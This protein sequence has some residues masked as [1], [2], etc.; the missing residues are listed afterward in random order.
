[1]GTTL[2]LALRRRMDGCV[3]TGTGNFWCHVLEGACASFGMELV[4]PGVVF[5][6]LAAALG[7]SPALMGALGA[8]GGLS[9]LVPLF[10][11]HRVEAARRKKR[12]VLLLG[13]GQ[14]LPFLVIPLLLFLMAESAPRACLLSIALVNLAAAMVVSALVPPWV[15][16]LSETIRPAR[17][18][19]L[20][21]YRNS[22]SSVLGLLAGVVSA[23][24]LSALAFPLGYVLLYLFAFGAMAASWLIFSLVD[25]LPARAEQPGS[26]AARSYFQGLF[27]A[28]RDDA[29]CR[30]YLVHQ[31]ISRMGMAVAP[32][33]ALVAVS[34]FGVHP[35]LAVGAFLTA[36]NSAKIAGSFAFP[37]FSE[38]A[39]HRWILGI[40]TGLHAAAALAAACAPSGEWFVAV[41]FLSGLG[42]AA[43]TVSG[44]PLT[45]A[46]APGGR[47]VGYVTLS[48][49]VLAPVGMLA[50]LAA[51][52]ALSWAGHEIV[53][54]LAA[55][56]TLA[57]LLPLGPS[58]TV[59][60]SE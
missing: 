29:I 37:F 20:L 48:M 49:A 38:R 33:Y 59:T 13:I 17:M 2:A 52:F 43:K 58:S 45:M 42:T 46:V 41:F 36:E 23:A 31:G 30:R 39:G 19:R 3:E 16:L 24:L 51:G 26:P 5:P 56:V 12:L 1:M 53:F 10:V 40:G 28:L 60:V 11:A 54:G 27:S 8:L 47:T 7:V 32:F 55:L 15:A 18:A 4:A 50:A 6:V 9:F 57:A 34:H 25:E 21:G 22:I 44:L 14:R 35:A